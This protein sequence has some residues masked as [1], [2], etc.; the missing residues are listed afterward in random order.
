MPSVRTLEVERRVT[1]A[2]FSERVVFAATPP[3][4]SPA[5]AAK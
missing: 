5:P 3:S 4:A 2:G 1:A